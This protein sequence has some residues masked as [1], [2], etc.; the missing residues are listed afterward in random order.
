MHKTKIIIFDHIR[1]SEAKC[2]AKNILQK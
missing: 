2:P 1:V